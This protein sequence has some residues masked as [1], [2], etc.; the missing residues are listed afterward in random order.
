LYRF[1][2]IEPY[3]II[4]ANTADSSLLSIIFTAAMLQFVT[5][6]QQERFGVA[7]QWASNVDQ[8]TASF[9]LP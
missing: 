9:L 5:F 4:C 2:R 1:L 6:I 3:Q 7:L 8:R